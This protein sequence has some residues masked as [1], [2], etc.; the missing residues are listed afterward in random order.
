[1]ARHRAKYVACKD[2]KAVCL[3]PSRRLLRP[4]RGRG[5]CR[6][7]RLREE[8]KREMPQ[9]TGA[10]DAALGR[11]QRVLC[12]P[13]GSAKDAL[14]DKL[15]RVPQCKA[16]ARQQETRALSP[17][18]DSIYKIMHLAG[19]KAIALASIVRREAVGRV[20]SAA[21]WIASRRF[22]RSV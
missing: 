7:R 4:Q 2:R 8:V 18:D 6:P 16:S 22:A 14:H 13:Y 11:P 20:P 21:S 5:S 15:D 19:R 10:V 3:R 12:L 17:D 9:D 1:M